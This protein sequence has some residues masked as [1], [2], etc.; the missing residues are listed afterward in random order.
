MERRQKPERI[1][2][3]KLMSRSRWMCFVLIYTTQEHDGES[4]F[5]APLRIQDINPQDTYVFES[6]GS[7]SGSI[8]QRYGSGS[9][10]H[11]VKIV[12]KT[13]IPVVL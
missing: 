3:S 9:F 8:G 11:L 7:G 12:R 6:L 1:L 4:Y 13:L 2:S 5:I 10:Y